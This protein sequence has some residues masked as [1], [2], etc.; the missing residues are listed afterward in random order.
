MRRVASTHIDFAI[1]RTPQISLNAFSSNLPGILF[2]ALFGP[3]AAGFYYIAYRVLQMPGQLV[4]D[5]VKK[6]FYPKAAKI[7]HANGDLRL[8]V[9]KATLMLGLVGAV[10]LIVVLAFGPFLFSFA[11]GKQW[12][13]AGVYAKWLSLWIFSVFMNGP[14]VSAIPVIGKQAALLIYEIVYSIA[15]AAAIAG[16]AL[17]TRD[18]LTAIAAYAV[19]GF[20]A[21][22]FLILYTISCCPKPLA[23]NHPVRNNC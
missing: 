9:V 2:T 8:E 10:P 13:L 14:S 16:T 5:A 4:A 21:N 23:D 11:F 1:Y 22:L 15:K 12:V 3:A 18:A 19:V 20:I 17:I 6:A 7:I